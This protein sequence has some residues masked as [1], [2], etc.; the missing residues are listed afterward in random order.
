MISIQL[1]NKVGPVKPLNGVNNGPL[2]SLSVDKSWEFREARIPFSRLHD[3][4]GSYGSGVFVNIHCVFPNFEADVNSPDSYFFDATD[5]Y[6]K[7]I[8]DAGTQ[9]FYRLGETIENSSRL[10]IFAKPPKDFVK[11]AQICEHIVMHYNEGWANGFHYNIQYW[12]IWNEPENQSMWSGGTP[13]QYYELY[14]ITATLLKSRFPNIKVGGFAS[15]G[16]YDITRPDMTLEVKSWIPFA[17]NFFRYITRPDK[18][19]PLDFFSW[20]QYPFDPK[21]VGIHARFAQSLLNKYGFDNAENI[22]NEW[23]YCDTQ[24][25]ED[26][27]KRKNHFGAAMMGAVLAQMQKSPIT[28]AMYY[29]A[30]IK[31]TT[32]CGIFDLYTKKVLKPYYSLF[33][34]GKLLDLGTEVES[35]A[36]GENVYVIAASDGKSSGVFVTNF[37]YLSR[38]ETI[39]FDR[40]VQVKAVYA[41]NGA[42][43]NAL[44][45]ERVAGKRTQ[46]IPGATTSKLEEDYAA[47]DWTQTLSLNLQPYEI[48]YLELNQ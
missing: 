45:P 21:E 44:Q 18:K 37:S 8:I 15:S 26:V 43:T 25:L 38:K 23:N 31:R 11:W 36:D 35:H 30:E 14:H 29:D 13:E 9:V 28:A 46:A 42:V 2:G 3:T 22:L 24:D 12:E 10:R 41:T 33:Y 5:I 17:E 47:G 48:L 6:L 4:E 7:A 39:T 1:E 34:F 32:Y 20:H 27:K 40:E 16:F 19:S